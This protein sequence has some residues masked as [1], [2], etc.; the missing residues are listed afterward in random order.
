MQMLVVQ[1]K[2]QHLITQDLKWLKKEKKKTH[3][4]NISNETIKY[5]LHFHFWF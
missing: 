1:E 2:K 3:T 5:I 4:T